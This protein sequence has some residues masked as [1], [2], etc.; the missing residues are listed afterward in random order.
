MDR[1]GHDQ[2][3]AIDASKIRRELGWKPEHDFAGGMELTLR[4][5]LDNRAWCDAVQSEA[6][7]H[8]E[9]LGLTNKRGQTK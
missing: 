2:R 5:Y 4:W 3:Y 6:S 9:R 1:L 7:Y 8:R